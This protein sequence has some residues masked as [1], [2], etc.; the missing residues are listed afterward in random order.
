[1]E[2]E[3]FAKGEFELAR[4]SC[5]KLLFTSHRIIRQDSH[6]TAISIT[7]VKDVKYINRVVKRNNL[8]GALGFIF[9][10]GA[11]VLGI[12][13]GFVWLAGL[14]FVASAASVV[15]YF[16]V[17]REVITIRTNHG[18][19]LVV[20]ANC[21]KVDPQSLINSLETARFERFNQN[22]QAAK[23]PKRETRIIQIGA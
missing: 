7:D 9:L 5:G 4:S 2:T 17:Q 8:L 20:K 16:A 18:K 22:Y 11:V 10:V 6:G 13:L 21:L 12:G 1:M 15:M 14:S 23:V 3:L 19:K